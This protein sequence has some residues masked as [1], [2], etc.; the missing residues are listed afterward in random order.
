MLPWPPLAIIGR[1]FRNDLRLVARDRLLVMLL[2][3][4]AVLAVVVRYV[5]PGLDASLAENGILPSETTDLRFSDTFEL[6]VV[7]IGLWQ[8]ALMPGTVF[9]F[10]LLDEKE[11][12]TLVAMRVTP[13]PLSA[14]L[15]Y[16]VSVPAAFAFVFALVLVPAIGFAPVA[17]WQL[18]PFAIGA[19]TTAPVATLL[20][21]M[22]AADKVQGFAFTKFGGVA[23]LI[24]IFGWFVPLPWQWL[25]CAFGP[26]AIA[27]GY[28]MAAHGAAGWWAPLLFG[29]ALQVWATAALLRRFRRTAPA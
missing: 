14:Y 20:I 15:A 19:A 21:A 24:I 28:W 12:G 25:L 1:L 18:V 22:F 3:L 9:A 2:C 17:P 11:D 26:F 13:V 5:L 29:T 10:L 8:A 27:K 4:V 6:W 7:F 16:R 23:G